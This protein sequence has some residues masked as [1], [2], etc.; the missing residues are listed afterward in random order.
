[1]KKTKANTG[2]I[3]VAA[4]L[5]SRLGAGTRKAMVRLA[6][7]PM[8]AHALDTLM[9]ASCVAEVVVVAHVQDLKALAQ[10]ASKRPWPKPLSLAQGGDTRQESVWHGAQVLGQAHAVILV[11]DAARPFVTKRQVE[12]C[13]AGAAQGACALL[14]VPVKD[15]I[16]RQIGKKV[17]GLKREELWA[18]QTPQALPAKDYFKAQHKAQCLKKTAT[19]E[20][21]LA[22]LIGLKQALVMGAYDNFKVTTP[23]DL[24]LAKLQI[25]RKN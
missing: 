17:R 18:A 23:E 10:W 22:E 9:Q 15:S 8:L 4:G 20:A 19:D 2:A 11:H 1:M 24:A 7:K 5:G 3:L 14:A 21:G 25:R 12:S 6:G 13:A 16:K